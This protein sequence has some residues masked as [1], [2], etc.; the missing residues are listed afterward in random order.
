MS[1][2]LETRFPAIQPIA[3]SI[4]SYFSVLRSGIL[5]MILCMNFIHYLSPNTEIARQNVSQ[6]LL[7]FQ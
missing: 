7:C 4:W 5:L 1:K 3:R 2:H 6:P